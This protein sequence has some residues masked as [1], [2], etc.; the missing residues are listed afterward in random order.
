MGSGVRCRRPAQ[1]D[2]LG[3]QVLSSHYRYRYS[4]TY[5]Y[6]RW[7]VLP[8]ARYAVPSSLCRHLADL[9]GPIESVKDGNGCRRPLTTATDLTV[10][11]Q[12]TKPTARFHGV[13][14]SRSVLIRDKDSAKIPVRLTGNGVGRSRAPLCAKTELYSCSPGQFA[15]N[16]LRS[17][18]GRMSCPPL[19]R[20]WQIATTSISA[21]LTLDRE[22]TLSSA[23]ETSSVP[24]RSPRPTGLSP[25]YLDRR[26]EL[27][28]RLAPLRRMVASSARQFARTQATPS[29][30]LS[31]VS[32]PLVVWSRPRSDTLPRRRQSSLQGVLYAGQRLP[33][34]R[35]APARFHSISR[36][37]HPLH[38]LTWSSHLL[39]HRRRRCALF[40]A[41]S[42][43]TC[44]P[45]WGTVRPPPH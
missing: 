27:R 4:Q 36:R 35:K 34:R 43:W 21:S 31:T 26:S 41:G 10:E 19:K 8:L 24:E 6:S 33:S 42:G 14:G 15:I 9:P 38:R 1:A 16:R 29:L 13:D 2:D 40:R 12:R 7:P 17:P 37:P 32:F 11:V 28:R 18:L 44:R 3:H 25:H 5:R 45:R 22:F 20:S 23:Y 30:L 39:F